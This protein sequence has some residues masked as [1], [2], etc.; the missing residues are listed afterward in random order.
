MTL[1]SID[2]I[3][4]TLADPGGQPFV[5]GGQARHAA[6]AAI[7]RP[8][9]GHTELLF[10]LRSKK[11]GDP[12]SG[13]MAFPGGH[14]ETEDSC[15]RET[16][17][18]ET[19]EEIGL[20]LVRDGRYLGKLEDVNATPRGSARNMVVSPFVFLLENSEAQVNMNYEVAD[21][22]WTS[23]DAMHA[24]STVTT[25]DY[26]VQGQRQSFPG[27][28]VGEQVVWG[29]TLRMLDHFFTRIDGQWQ[30]TYE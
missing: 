21:V 29:L 12:W 5:P 30:P 15:L 3:E 24:G 10:I 17:E 13:Q 4:K 6:V 26:E 20:D 25:L 2:N 22:L 16:A 28:S 8:G 9:A 19:W 18:R 23:L 7:I 14:Y 27:Y 11:E 1:M